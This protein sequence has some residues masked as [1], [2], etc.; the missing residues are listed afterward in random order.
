[1]NKVIQKLRDG[2]KS[3]ESCSKKFKADEEEEEYYLG[4]DHVDERKRL[5]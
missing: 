5:A 4:K 1:M 3:K 2:K